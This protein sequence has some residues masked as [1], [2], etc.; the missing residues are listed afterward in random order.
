[1]ATYSPLDLNSKPVLTG[2]PGAVVYD[3]KVTCT[4]SAATADVIRFMRIPAGTRLCEISIRVA[5][6]FGATAP[7]TLRLTPA[8]G[9]TATELVAAGDTVL[10]SINKKAMVFEPVTV[11][12]DS[13]LECLLGT[14]GTGAAGV[15][16]AVALGQHVGAA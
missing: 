5:T 11:T 9:S 4:A 6:A 14:V 1:M 16:T 7:S 10:A 8:D 2:I 3:G 13:F 15:A 12:K